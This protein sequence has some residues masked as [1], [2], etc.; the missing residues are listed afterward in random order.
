MQKVPF[1]QE[2][3][4]LKRQQLNE[5]PAPEFRKQLCLIQHQ[6]RNWIVDNF[7]LNSEQVDYIDAMPDEFL[8]Y[9]GLQTA[10]GFDYNL[11]MTLETPE[12]YT[13]PLAN[14]RK[15]EPHIEG[16]GS[17]TPGEPPV[18]NHIQV[19]IRIRL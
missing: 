8:S 10:I 6:T 18:I 17:W 4:D 13:A 15:V 14:K 3:L 16:S 2:G 7:L 9:I 19:G 1:N 11:D 5:L 12:T